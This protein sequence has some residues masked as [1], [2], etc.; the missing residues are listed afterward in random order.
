LIF[1]NYF[2]TIT[3]SLAQSFQTTFPGLLHSSEFQSPVR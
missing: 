3:V 1:P 2:S